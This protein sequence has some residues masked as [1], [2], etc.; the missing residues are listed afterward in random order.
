VA[1][2]LLEARGLPP[3]LVLQPPIDHGREVDVDG[4]D[5]ELAG[6]ILC[7]RRLRFARGNGGGPNEKSC[8]GHCEVTPI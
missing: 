5:H 2:E 8:C 4:L 1:G 7:C 3:A 6:G